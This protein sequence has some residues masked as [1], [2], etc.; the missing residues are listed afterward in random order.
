MHERGKE[1]DPA[2]HNTILNADLNK[3]DIIFGTPYGLHTVIKISQKWTQN[4]FNPKIICFEQFDTLFTY[5]L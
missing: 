5:F 1:Y 3:S 4:F 2:V